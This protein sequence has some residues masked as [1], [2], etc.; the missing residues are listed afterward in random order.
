MYCLKLLENILLNTKKTL[1]VRGLVTGATYLEDKKLISLCGYSK[2]GKTF[3]YILYD[4]KND[5]FLSGNK[6][7][8]K[9]RLWFHQIEG[10]ATQDGKLFY[11]TNESFIKKPIANNPQQIH[12]FDLSSYLLHYLQ[13]Y[14]TNISI[15]NQK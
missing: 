2:K 3:I 1:N 4:F 10:I 8:F 13:K 7:K 6:R 14:Q 11:L 12:H 9:L 15:L 5:D